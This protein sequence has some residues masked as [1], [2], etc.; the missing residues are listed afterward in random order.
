MAKIVIRKKLK[1]SSRD[2]L[3]RQMKDPFV[4]KAKKDG[5]RSRAAYKLLEIQNKYKIIQ[6]NH[7]I[8]DLGSAPGGWS[9]VAS[10]ICLRV[11]AV[12][13][14]DMDDIPNVDFIKGDF[15]DKETSEK[16][17]NSLKNKK[18]NVIISDMAPSTCGIKKIDHIRIMGLIEEV[19]EFCKEF[20]DEGGSMVV[21]VFQGGTENSLLS[22]LKKYFKKISH[23]KPDS[24]RK[25]S[26]EMY[27]VAIGFSRKLAEKS[28]SAI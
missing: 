11:L 10:G 1:K 9:Q 3:I 27:L 4:A 22:E 5:Y 13:L 7:E 2:W 6:K 24:S 20:L 14:L 16:L 19:F 26:S 18:A 8:I 25:E 28:T 21:K 15:L 17:K 12:D 23:F